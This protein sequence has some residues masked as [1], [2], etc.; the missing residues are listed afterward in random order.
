MKLVKHGWTG[1]LWRKTT[2]TILLIMHLGTAYCDAAETLIKIV[3]R[4]T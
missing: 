2:Q 4:S 3:T 1:P